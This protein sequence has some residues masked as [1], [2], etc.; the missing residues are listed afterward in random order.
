MKNNAL[1]HFITSIKDSWTGLNSETVIKSRELLK[2]LLKTPDSEPWLADLHRQKQES[3]ELYRN[4]EHGFILLAHVEKQEQYRVPHN[5]GA[6]W[7]FYAV[8]HGAMEMSTYSQVTDQTGKTALVSRGA[9]T[10]N[11]G[12]CNVYLPGDIHDTKC[13]SEYVLMFRLTSCDFKA[14]K[15]EGRLI[16]Y[17]G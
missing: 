11:A 14:E 1:E 10:I 9:A 15:R 2:Q 4:P 13:L 3:V 6:G 5:H 12:E 17:L 16:Q 7:V 8:Q